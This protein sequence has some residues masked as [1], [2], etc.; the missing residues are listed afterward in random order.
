MSGIVSSV[1]YRDGRRAG[2]VD[3]DDV[4]SVLKQPDA[5]VWIGLYEPSEEELR[6]V[7]AAFG[8]HDLAVE[9]AHRAHQRPKLEIYGE[10]V[11]IAVRTAQMDP[12]ECRVLFGETHF[13]V[14]QR[15]LVSV[16]HGSSLSYAPVRSRAEASPQLLRKGPIFVLYMLMDFIVDQYFPVIDRLTQE[17]QA[18][19]ERVF[20]E[21]FSRETISQ[22][23]DLRRQLLAIKSAV[24]PL[25][26]VC[27]RL[28]RFDL[29]LVP[30]DTRLYFR[31]VYDHA[32]RLNEMVDTL[33][34]LLASALEA[35]LA[36]V[37]IE[38]NEA[39]KRFA[40]WAAILAVP[41]MVAG[42]YGMN[43]EHMP[44]LQWRF[45]YPMVIGATFALCLFLYVRFKR[46]GWL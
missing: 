15:Y 8:L 46:A 16:R 14:G 23:H 29:G 5:F 26:D 22:F 11:F 4:P 1:I 7:Q 3:I 27:N 40:G 44:E 45:G 36:Y 28:M 41:T 10:S 9:D 19:E 25:I 42:V 13:F 35:G 24:S 21:A 17:L 12:V 43:F 18:I 38:Q 33:R 37:S 31:D 2:D 34:E 30:D 32:I 6:R 39:M 20:G